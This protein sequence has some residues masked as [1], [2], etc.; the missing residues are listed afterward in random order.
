MLFHSYFF[1]WFF[2]KEFINDEIIKII[3]DVF[4]NKQANY[5]YYLFQAIY[6][7]FGAK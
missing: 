3:E 4:I 7:V 2:Q 6:F 5:Y 1:N